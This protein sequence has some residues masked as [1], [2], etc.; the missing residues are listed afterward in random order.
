MNAPFH[1][2]GMSAGDGVEHALLHLVDEKDIAERLTCGP[3]SVVSKDK[4]IHCHEDDSISHPTP[5]LS[6]VQWAEKFCITQGERCKPVPPQSVLGMRKHFTDFTQQ[7]GP[8][9]PTDPR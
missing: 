2:L 3:T 6:G 5:T 1:H 7:S 8:P 4:Q 9:G